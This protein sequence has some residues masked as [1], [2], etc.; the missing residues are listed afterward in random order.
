MCCFECLF[1]LREDAHYKGPCVC[2]RA[3][4]PPS[5]SREMTFSTEIKRVLLSLP[6]TSI[7]QH[8]AQRLNRGSGRCA[9]ITVALSGGRSRANSMRDTHAGTV[10]SISCAT[11]QFYCWRQ[12]F[13]WR[14]LHKQFVTWL[15]AISGSEIITISGRENFY[16]PR[17]DKTSCT[18]LRMKCVHE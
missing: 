12:F 14:I 10:T 11:F 3:A 18:S 17:E 2:I 15:L 9:L 13:R 8:F 4:P 6:L 16:Y 7:F 5:P 1:N